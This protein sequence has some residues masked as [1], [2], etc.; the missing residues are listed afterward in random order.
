VLRARTTRNC[1]LTT[2]RLCT[3]EPARPRRKAHA[4]GQ[5]TRQQRTPSRRGGRRGA[6]RARLRAPASRAPRRDSLS[7]QLFD[8]RKKLRGVFPAPPRP[9]SPSQRGR[10]SQA[11]GAGAAHAAIHGRRGALQH[12]QERR[13]RRPVPE[14]A[15]CAAPAYTVYAPARAMP[16]APRCAGERDEAVQR[17]REAYG[18]RAVLTRRAPAFHCAC[19]LRIAPARQHTARRVK[20]FRCLSRTVRP[21]LHAQRRPASAQQS[22]PQAHAAASDSEAGATTEGGALARLHAHHAR[23]CTRRAIPT[24]VHAQPECIRSATLE[25]ASSR[26]CVPAATAAACAARLR[27]P[28]LDACQLLAHL[29]GCCHG[30]RGARHAGGHLGV[31]RRRRRELRARG[32][33]ILSRAQRRRRHNLRRRALL[34]RALAHLAQRLRLRSSGTVRSAGGPSQVSSV[35]VPQQASTNVA[36]ACLLRVAPRAVLPKLRQL[37]LRRQGGGGADTG[38]QQQ[39]SG[40]RVSTRAHT[41]CLH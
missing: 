7:R 38:T 17:S 33:E 2:E 35:C 41:A 4:P 3:R 34:R 5:R 22:M 6:H 37:V 14:H 12:G 15:S 19:K 36:R 29:G 31:R 11:A 20:T 27:E 10:H 39:R 8:A 24:R 9:R 25:L 13:S 32:F 21:R 18:A 16:S 23:A 30:I 40:L 28:R 26:C 1:L